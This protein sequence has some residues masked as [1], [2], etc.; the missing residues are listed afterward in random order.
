MWLAIGLPELL[1][2]PL[3]QLHW[4]LQKATESMTIHDKLTALII[5]YS[6]LDLDPAG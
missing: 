3:G 6:S 1:R 4:P 2:Q 5:N